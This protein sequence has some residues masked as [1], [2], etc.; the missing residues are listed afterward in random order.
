[1]KKYI[2]L[3][4]ILAMLSIGGCVA[5]NVAGKYVSSN[6]SSEYMQLNA[7]GSFYVYQKA[8]NFS[9]TYKVEDDKIFL[10]IQNNVT[11]EGKIE[12]NNIID[13]Q[14]IFWKKQEE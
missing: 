1:M 2:G 11:L 10:T 13:N 9:G 8:W 14:D 4:L 7:V 5:S 12:G 3:I 6:D